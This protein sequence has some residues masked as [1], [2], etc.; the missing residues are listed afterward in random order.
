MK[1]NKLKIKTH[2]KNLKDFEIDFSDKEG[3]TVLIGNN[4]SGKSNI[5]EAISSV[6]AGLYNKIYNPSF[7]YELS[8]IKDSYNVEV[9]YESGV[10][11]IKVNG[12]FTSLR[13]EYLP[14]KIIAS[15]SGEESRLWDKYYLPFYQDYIKAI[16]GKTVPDSKLIFINKYYWNIALLVLHFYDFD[17]FKDIRDFCKKT[18]G[19]DK[20]NNITF[21]FDIPTLNTWSRNPVKNM[22]DNLNPKN[23]TSITIT[24]E[25]FKNRLGFINEIDLFKYLTAAFMPKDYKVITKIDI[26]YNTGLKAE[27][28]SEGEKKLLLIMLILEVIGDE[29]SLILLD[30]PDSH[31]HPSNKE[32]IKELLEKYSNRENILTTHSPTLTHHFDLKHVTML[33]KKENNSVQIEDMEKQRIVYELTK[34]IW[35][36]QEQNIFLNSKKDILLVEGKTD[37]VFLKKALKVLKDPNDPNNRYNNLEFEYLPCGGAEGVKLLTQK[38]KPKVGQHIIAFFDSDQSGWGAINKIFEDEKKKYNAENYGSHRKHGEIW[39]AVYPIRPRYQGGKIFN[40]EDYFSKK[41]L[42][43][44]VLQFKGLD[45]IVTK[46]Q[47]KSQLAENCEGFPDSEF[48]PFKEVFELILKIKEE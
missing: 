40:I 14:N 48:Q 41:R 19:V 46:S 28:L 45:S 21:N 4:G 34:G 37:E 15:Y 42:T 23:E 25:E 32:K 10:Y 3:I 33:S 38:F 43:K 6:F 16:K 17:E 18:L 2:F 24:L 31:I 1:L 9:K 39:I 8:Y 5:L 20:V 26:D 29:N 47:V 13:P 12:H 36:Y 27:S 11:E 30:E 44:Y 7:E 22:V 35:S